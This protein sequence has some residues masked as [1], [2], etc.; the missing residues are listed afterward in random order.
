MTNFN[1]KIISSGVLLDYYRVSDKKFN[2]VNKYECKMKLI[3][4]IIIQSGY[5]DLVLK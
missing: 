2:L 1:R 3:S 5:Y 4:F